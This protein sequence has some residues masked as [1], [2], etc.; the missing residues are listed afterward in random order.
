[1]CIY[2]RM[3]KLTSVLTYIRALRQRSINLFVFTYR[4]IWIEFS[5]YIFILVYVY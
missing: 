2:D 5:V 1:M 4:D 3:H